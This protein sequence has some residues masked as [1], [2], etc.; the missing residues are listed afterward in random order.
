MSGFLN[1]NRRYAYSKFSSFNKLCRHFRVGFYTKFGIFNIHVNLSPAENGAILMIQPAVMAI[2][3]TFSER[4]S[5][6]YDSRILSSL[7]MLISAFGVGMLAFTSC[8][9][10]MQFFFVACNFRFGP[11]DFFYTQLRIQ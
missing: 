4:L 2:F 1:Q 9:T 6:K 3:A 8:E 7:G 11:L 5:D 10:P